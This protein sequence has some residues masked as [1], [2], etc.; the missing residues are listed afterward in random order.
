M[1]YEYKTI[2]LLGNRL[3]NALIN[4]ASYRKSF[5][6]NLKSRH[7]PA[8]IWGT[9]EVAH[10][11]YH[12]M[13]NSGI[14]FDGFIDNDYE[15]HGKE[16][17]DGVVC[18]SPDILS[19]H[20][21]AIIIVGVGMHSRE[22]F[23]QLETMGIHSA[24]DATT[25]LLNYSFSEPENY[26]IDLIKSSVQEVFSILSDDVSKK[27]LY[28]RL[29]DF[30]EFDAIMG[31]PSYF[32]DVFE[33][34]QYFPEDIVSFE[35]RDILVDCGAFNGDT[36]KYFL[37]LNLP[38]SKY[39]SYELSRSNYNKLIEFAQK[40]TGG[41]TTSLYKCRGWKRQC[42]YHVP[43][44]CVFNISQQKRDFRETGTNVG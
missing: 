22:V 43:G 13:K 15:K 16:I 33:D 9:G 8:Y 12:D 18:F 11:F 38:F 24:V 39:I 3:K 26:D 34:H 35:E 40:Y 28:R 20:K 5:T 29:Q 4:R 27:V 42:G 2:A 44:Q 14:S 10:H 23:E 32:Y 6:E 7:H 30:C 17:V 37:S 41:G 19:E 25:F 31:K 1:D 21:D 36:L